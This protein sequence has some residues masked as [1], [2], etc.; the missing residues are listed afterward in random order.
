MPVKDCGA[1]SFCS[2]SAIVIE[3][4][5][6]LVPLSELPKAN[7]EEKA[8]LLFLSVTWGTALFPLI[9][10]FGGVLEFEFGVDLDGMDLVSASKLYVDVGPP[11]LLAFFADDD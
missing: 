5:F 2:R 9:E 1:F 6:D 7:K 3:L 8:S 10:T 11:A 4:V